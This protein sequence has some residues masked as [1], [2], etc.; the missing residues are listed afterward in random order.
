MACDGRHLVNDANGPACWPTDF[1]AVLGQ[2]VQVHIEH[3]L[4]ERRLASA[5]LSETFQPEDLQMCLLG[6]C[7]SRTVAESEQTVEKAH[8]EL[9]FHFVGRPPGRIL[10]VELSAAYGCYSAYSSRWGLHVKGQQQLARLLQLCGM[11]LPPLLYQTWVVLHLL[12][13]WRG[14]FAVASKRPE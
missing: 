8:S 1:L 14:A 3:F 5:H 9:F 6:P 13:S 10:P 2:L 7:S 12:G 4:A 11:N